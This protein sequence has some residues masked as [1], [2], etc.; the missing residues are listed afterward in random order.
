MIFEDNIRNLMIRGKRDYVISLAMLKIKAHMNYAHVKMEVLK[1][2]QH[3][4]EGAVKC[5]WRVVGGPGFFKLLLTF[6]R[7][8]II[9]SYRSK[10]P[11]A[12]T[13]WI[14]GFSIFHINGEGKI[15]KHVCDK[16]FIL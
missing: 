3:P 7:M 15:Y 12:N 10:T 11:N 14:D 4:D 13:E 1:I 16:V 2:S 5:R 8:N 9:Q 6:W